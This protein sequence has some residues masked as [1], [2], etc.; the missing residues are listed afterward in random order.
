MRSPLVK[1]HDEYD[2]ALK[3][4]NR[5]KL[6]CIKKDVK[7]LKSQLHSILELLHKKI[8]KTSHDSKFLPN[9]GFIF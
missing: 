1:L 9:L 5:V 8:C 6:I 2:V 7:L 4:I 3:L